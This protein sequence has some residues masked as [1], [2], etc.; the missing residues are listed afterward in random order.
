M[1][2]LEKIVLQMNSK[3]LEIPCVYFGMSPHKILSQG[4][5]QKILQI[6]YNMG[7]GQSTSNFAQDFFREDFSDSGLSARLCLDKGATRGIL[8][9]FGEFAGWD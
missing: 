1:I 2:R 7:Y 4:M 3:K 6:W 8:G 5:S 9:R